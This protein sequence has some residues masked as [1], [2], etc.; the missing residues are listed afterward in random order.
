M[1]LESVKVKLEG[2]ASWGWCEVCVLF[3]GP[4]Q[5]QA[6]QEEI[7]LH[8]HLIHKNIVRYYGAFVE[9]EKLKIFMEYVPGGM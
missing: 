7:R 8:R 2:G 4:R 6:T 5:L 9:D 1:G 3:D